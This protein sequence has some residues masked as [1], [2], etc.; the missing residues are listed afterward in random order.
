[1]QGVFDVSPELAQ[2]RAAQFGIPTIYPTLDT[3]IAACDVVDVCT[4]PHTHAA[5]ARQVIAAGKHLLIEKPLVTDAA[6]WDALLALLESSPSKIA[7]VHNLKFTRGIARAKQWVSRGRIGDLISIERHFLV[8]PNNDRMLVG[9]THWSH[10]LPGGR[11]FETLPHELYLLHYFAGAL[12]VTNVSVLRTPAAPQGAPADEV[13]VTLK[14]GTL[15]ATLHYSAHCELN[16]RG[17]TLYG[18]RGMIVVD[19]LSDLALLSTSRDK[20]W[21]RVVS[22]PLLDA[23]AAILQAVPDRAASAVQRA[24]GETAHAD[25]IGAFASYVAGTGESPSPLDEID[26]VVRNAERI[27]RAIDGERMQAGPGYLRETAQE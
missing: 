24:Q 16:R 3:L 20:K 13:L 17:M 18:T 23:G 9:N 19:T 8:S 10:T 5:I 12:E 26:Y 6:D 14:N 27:G 22:R 1:V 25:F 2:K 11:W 4:P 21:K 15:L 7:V